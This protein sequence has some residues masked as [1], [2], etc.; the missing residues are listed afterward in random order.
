MVI[1]AYEASHSAKSAAWHNAHPE[2]IITEAAAESWLRFDG[3][4]VEGETLEDLFF[5]A[6]G[7]HPQAHNI[8]EGTGPLAHHK[9]RCFFL[10]SYTRRIRV[11]LVEA[12]NHRKAVR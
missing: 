9:G 10:A 8:A 7:Q 12:H 1:Q 2:T 4:A 6:T 3:R 5:I 11:A